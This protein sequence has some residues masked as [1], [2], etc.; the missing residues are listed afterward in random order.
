MRSWCSS[1][2]AEE[3]LAVTEKNEGVLRLTEAGGRVYEGI[4]YRLKF[5]SG[6]ADNLKNLRRCGLLFKRR[7]EL[8]R[9][10]LNLLEEPRV[11]RSQ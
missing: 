5:E 6:T 8:A 3:D 7:T 10:C 9:P 11:S 4:E 1:P 2:P